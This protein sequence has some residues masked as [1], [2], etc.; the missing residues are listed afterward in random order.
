MQSKDGVM[1]SFG[2]LSLL[3]GFNTKHE[4]ETDSQLHFN[5]MTCFRHFSTAISHNNLAFDRANSFSDT[6]T[7]Q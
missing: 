6:L 1:S 5:I 3:K 4:R 7:Q 2:F